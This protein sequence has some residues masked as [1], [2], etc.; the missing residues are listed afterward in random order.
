MGD[1]SIT[2]HR[3]LKLILNSVLTSGN[4]NSSLEVRTSAA[5]R[6]FAD[7]RVSQAHQDCHLERTLSRREGDQRDTDPRQRVAC[8]SA[9]ST[10]VKMQRSK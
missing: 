2:P 6:R 8:L 7:A 5:I 3:H 10:L 9:K 1:L 4:A